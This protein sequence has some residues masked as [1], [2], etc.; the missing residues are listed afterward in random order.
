MSQRGR[1]L[2]GVVTVALAL[3][4]A[5]GGAYALSLWQIRRSQE[6]WCPTLE[7]IAKHPPQPGQPASSVQV[8]HRLVRLRWEIGCR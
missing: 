1:L 2:L 4:V 8:Y 5:I 7:L 3:L 6:L